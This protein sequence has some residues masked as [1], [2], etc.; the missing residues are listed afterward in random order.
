MKQNYKFIKNLNF[1]DLDKTVKCFLNNIDN[2]INPR[3]IDIPKAA[4]ESPAWIDLQSQ[5]DEKADRMICLR[6]AKILNKENQE[7]LK[8]VN[9]PKQATYFLTNYRKE[10]D[11]PYKNEYFSVKIGNA[12]IM[13]AYKLK[14]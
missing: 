5:V 1:D 8:Y 9:S 11:P 6:Y 12:K 4:R 14:E 7:R 10:L 2:S 3:K 13:T